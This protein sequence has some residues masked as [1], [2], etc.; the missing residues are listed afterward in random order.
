MDKVQL[1]VLTRN[2]R[3]AKLLPRGGSRLDP[4][5]KTRVSGLRRGHKGDQS[6]LPAPWGWVFW[7]PDSPPQGLY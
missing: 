4:L 6:S 1:M 5:T 7:V 2:N 3:L